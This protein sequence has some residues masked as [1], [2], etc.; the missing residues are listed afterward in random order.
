MYIEKSNKIWTKRELYDIVV[1][2]IGGKGVP[3]LKVSFSQLPQIGF[4]HHFYTEQYEQRHCNPNMS[5]EVV[6]VKEGTFTAET[7]GRIGPVEPGSVLILLRAM[8]FHLF[9][10]AGEPQAHCSVQLVLDYAWEIMDD[11]TEAPFE[12]SGLL[13]PALVPPGEEAERI[14]EDLYALVAEANTTRDTPPLSA[15]VTALALLARL[16]RYFRRSRR[17]EHTPSLWEYRVK[18]YVAEHMQR[19]I[20]LE[21]IGVALGKSPNHLNTVFKASTGMSIRRYINR[22]RVRRIA[23]LMEGKGLP[24]K[25]ACENVAIYDVAYGYRL[26]KQHMG[27]TTREYLNGERNN[28]EEEV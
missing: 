13:L 28:R 5:L 19:D 2:T 4:A 15:S 9:A 24:F 22:Q 18:R 25:Q 7:Y 23:E 17:Q 3:Y 11:S 14:K 8:P 6:Y 21:E 10:P 26:F 12:F 20:S 16:D 1:E 27:V